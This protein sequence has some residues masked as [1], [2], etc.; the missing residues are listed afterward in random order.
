MMES[1]VAQTHVSWV[2]MQ[3]RK[4]A[5]ASQ[6]KKKWSRTNQFITL[7][8]ICFPKYFHVFRN[9]CKNKLKPSWFR[10]EVGVY[11][12]NG[13]GYF[14][15]ISLEFPMPHKIKEETSPLNWKRPC[16][17][18]DI[19]QVIFWYVFFIFPFLGLPGHDFVLFNKLM[20]VLIS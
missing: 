9:S 3:S 13:S 20:S 17:L 6:I 11:S 8:V 14:S 16:C 12:T 4:L 10:F 1:F 18:P 2:E 5:F 15:G 19:I 7:L